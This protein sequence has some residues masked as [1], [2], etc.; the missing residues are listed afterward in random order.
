MRK[1][2]KN[3]RPFSRCL[4]DARGMSSAS[5]T[6]R[7]SLPKTLLSLYLPIAFLLSLQLTWK[8]EREESTRRRNVGLSTREEVL[9]VSI[10]LY[11]EICLYTPTDRTMYRLAG[12]RL[13][14]HGADASACR[15]APLCVWPSMCRTVY[16]YLH[17]HTHRQ[18]YRYVYVDGKERRL[19][20]CLLFLDR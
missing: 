15:S 18:P 4:T 13:Y 20:I 2:K 9:A 1:K 8:L 7:K 3:L 19:D 14:V 6:T 10:K 16:T 11:M 12:L 5:K 17:I